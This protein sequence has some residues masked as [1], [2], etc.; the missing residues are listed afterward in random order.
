MLESTYP[1]LTDTRDQ[2]LCAATP[3]LMAPR[4]GILPPLALDQH[5]YIAT[6]DGIYLQTRSQAISLCLR[7]TK[8]PPCPMVF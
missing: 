3:M 7:I 5:R 4:F 2:V 8:T 6:T 1:Y